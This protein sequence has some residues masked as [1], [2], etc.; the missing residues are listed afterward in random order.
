MVTNCCLRDKRLRISGATIDR[1]LKTPHLRG[2][3]LLLMP[4]RGRHHFGKAAARRRPHG[5][6]TT[7]HTVR[8]AFSKSRASIHRR[9]ATTLG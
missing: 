9:T 2:Q 7:A 8:R 1:W 6:R 5:K 3:G 4:L